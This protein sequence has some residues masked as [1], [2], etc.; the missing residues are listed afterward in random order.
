MLLL[1]CMA[2]DF[3]GASDAASF[4]AKGGLSVQLFSG[5]PAPE[6]EPAEGVQ[7]VVIALKSRTQETAEA[8][9][10]TLKAAKWLR[11]QETQQYYLK[12]C[13]TFDSTPKG[14]IGPVADALMEF[15]DVPYTVLCP[16]LPVN[17]RTVSEGKLYVNGIPLHESHMKDHPLTPMWDCRIANLMDPQSG[18]DSLE[19]FAPQLKK[20]P[21]DIAGV[22]AEFG[23]ERDHFYVIPD[24]E[25]AEDGARIAQLFGGL[26]LLTGGSGLLEHLAARLAG[27]AE[28]SEALDVTSDGQAL[29]LAGS[30]SKPTLAQIR[31]FLDAGHP[32][33]KMDPVLLMSGEQTSE[34]FKVFIKEN[35]RPVLVYSSDTSENVRKI[36]ENGREKVAH[37]LESTTAELAEYAE[38]LG[39]TRFIVAGGETSG[40]VIQKLGYSSFRIGPSVAPGVPV[41]IPVDNDRV[42][43]VLK[44][45]GFGQEDF[46]V[47]A[48]EMTGGAD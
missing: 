36:Q 13:A 3:T 10:D 19:L 39:Y 9:S 16:A 26:R 15:L 5:V 32:G 17:G 38:D 14:N 18:Y 47:R 41:M 28:K 2:D 37:L 42:R 6:E 21:A 46:F 31:C 25:T 30:C 27:S 44:S 4:L 11:E 33:M 45:G 20:E 12:Y 35:D 23:K 24:Y 43:I 7:A 29:L 34:D 22:L 40:A 48:L 1:G 8:V